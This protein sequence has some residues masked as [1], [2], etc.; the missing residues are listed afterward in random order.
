M[1]EVVL[2]SSVI[3]ALIQGEPVASSTLDKLEGGVMSAVSFCEVLTKQIESGISE[4]SYADHL[5]GL[6]DRIEPF[7]PAH[8]RTASVLRASTRHKGLSLGD[9]AC[10]ALALKLIADVYTADRAWAAVDVGCRIHLIR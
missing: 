10:L 7:T 2:D 9:R 6:L 4:S 8:A 3:L 1:S 5:L